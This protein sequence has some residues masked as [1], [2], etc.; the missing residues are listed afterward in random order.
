MTTGNSGRAGVDRVVPYTTPTTRKR[1]MRMEFWE[2]LGSDSQNWYWHI[3]GTNGKI[4]ATGGEGFYN[5]SSCIR[6]VRSIAKKMNFNGG[7][8]WIDK[9]EHLMG[10]KVKTLAMIHAPGEAW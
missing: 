1:L 9:H 3:R 7:I 5:R 10:G 8:Y 2:G 6:A 4:V